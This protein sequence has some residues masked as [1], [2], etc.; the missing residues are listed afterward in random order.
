[1]PFHT[2]TLGSFSNL[3]EQTLKTEAAI[4]PETTMIAC[5]STGKLF[6]VLALFTVDAHAPVPGDPNDSMRSR[7]IGIALH[8]I[9]DISECYGGLPE[10]IGETMVEL[11]RQIREGRNR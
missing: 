11:E 10:M 1:M 9:D 7:I 2:L 4:G 6:S 8:E 5:T 3:M